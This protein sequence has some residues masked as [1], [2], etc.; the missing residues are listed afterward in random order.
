MGN[1]V[2]PPA[3]GDKT[4][5]MH[6]RKGLPVLPFTVDDDSSAHKR[7]SMRK[8]PEMYGFGK[9]VL[10]F[11]ASGFVVVALQQSFV[12]KSK[13]RDSNY[14]FHYVP[15]VDDEQQL[16][17]QKRPLDDFPSLLAALETSDVVALYFAASWCPMST[18]TTKLLDKHFRDALVSDERRISIVYVSS[19]K[20]EASFDAYVKPGWKTVPYTT[21]AKERSAMKRHFRT[22]A[23]R[24]MDE[25]GLET[26]DYEIPSLIVMAASTQQVITYTGIQD[27][28]ELGV[29][30]VDHWM[31]MKR[32]QTALE[33]K[34]DATS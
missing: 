17:K 24:E 14:Q 8:V 10:L 20:D 3:P 12:K 28:K 19:D 27:V 2:A 23:K 18:P 22:C 1:S 13:E 11:I 33:S 16:Q 15:I 25:V 6:N 32:L 7:R 4:P 30:A 21:N 29:A 9:F 5:K 26:R 34:Y 31:E